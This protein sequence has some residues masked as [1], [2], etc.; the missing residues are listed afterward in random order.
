MGK[1]RQGRQLLLVLHL[2]KV[3]TLSRHLFFPPRWPC[4]SFC[5]KTLRFSLHSFAFSYQRLFFLHSFFQ[6]DSP[7]PSVPLLLNP[8]PSAPLFSLSPSTAILNSDS[9]YLIL[10]TYLTLLFHL[11]YFL[12]LLSLQSLAQ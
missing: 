1:L 5:Q 2:L 9:L 8:T 3:S 6:H 11:L 12:L 4:C 10:L 7:I